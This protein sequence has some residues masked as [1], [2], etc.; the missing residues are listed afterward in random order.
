MYLENL[1]IENF[2]S[3]KLTTV[4]FQQDLTILAGAN[5][6]GKTNILD[7][8][9]LI[10]APADGRRT[11]YAEQEDIRRGGPTEFRLIG[12]FAELNDVQRG[13]FV[14]ALGEP[15][16]NGA[17]YGLRFPVPSIRRRRE[18][19]KFWAGPREG[20]DPEPEARELIRHVFFPALRNAQRELASGSPERIAFL[21][22]HLAQ[23]DEDRIK[24]LES[25]AKE[26]FSRI[27]QDPLLQETQKQVSGG[28]RDLTV[29]LQPHEA[30][31][32]FGGASLRQIARDLRFF[33]HRSGLEPRDLSESGLG[34]ANILYLATVLVELQA[35]KD[36]ELTLFLVEEPEAHLHPQFQAVI[37]QYLREQALQSHQQYGDEH[38]PER[39]AQD[40]PSRHTE[41]TRCAKG[42][43][44]PPSH[45]TRPRAPG[46]VRI[47]GADT[48]PGE[49]A[50]AV[51]AIVDSTRQLAVSLPRQNFVL[52]S[53][54]VYLRSGE[55][56]SMLKDCFFHSSRVDSSG[57]LAIIEGM[58]AYKQMS[59]RLPEALYDRYA[60]FEH[61]HKQFACAAGLLLY[62]ECDE[63]TQWIYRE[64][65]KAI[66]EGRADMRNPPASLRKLMP[67]K[68]TASKK[69]AR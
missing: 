24:S 10:T 29:G 17:T 39:D 8:L 47:I 68:K 30:T 5:N 32:K 60:D 43:R 14:T 23:G 66:A 26:A 61:G 67:K 7:A 64:W 56:A 45:H 65:A 4:H 36:A 55:I 27:E 35:A 38:A 28:L 3:C 13:L 9:R 51:A 11:R 20:G 31:L 2:R 42:R 12:K 1:Q 50:L 21:I 52:V 48:R 69:K 15:C 62:L 19:V 63:D 53:S 59:S 46:S 16:S 41:G 33:L 44:R 54:R 34:Y 40:K 57:R 22:Q 49:V 25:R 37:L 58:A 6:A 18:T